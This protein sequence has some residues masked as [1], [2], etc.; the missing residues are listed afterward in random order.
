MPHM[1]NWAALGLSAHDW[2]PFGWKCAL[3]SPFEKQRAFFAAVPL[4][5]VAGAQRASSISN[6]PIARKTIYWNRLGYEPALF[7]GSP[8]GC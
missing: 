7:Y 5:Q 2:G 8:S 3:C 4:L 6:S 1:L